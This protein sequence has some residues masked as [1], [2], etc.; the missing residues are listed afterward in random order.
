MNYGRLSEICHVAND[1]YLSC[2]AE[3]VDGRVVASVLPMFNRDWSESL[4]SLHVAHIMT[5]AIE[6]DFLQRELYPHKEL[7]NPT[8]MLLAAREL[9]IKVGFF[10]KT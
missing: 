3:G 1:E 10:G 9:L 5:L 4:L 7:E 8:E 2:F 6:V